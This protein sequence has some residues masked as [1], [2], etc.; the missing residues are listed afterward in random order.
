MASGRVPG[1]D[2]QLPPH[3]FGKHFG[4]KPSVARSLLGSASSKPTLTRNGLAAPTSKTRPTSALLEAGLPEPKNSL[5]AETRGTELGSSHSQVK[6]CEKEQV[7]RSLWEAGSEQSD[8]LLVLG[9]AHV[10]PPVE[11]SL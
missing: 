4:N 1:R 5:F 3:P 11:A 9:Q 6:N 8:H 2:A 10:S 7:G